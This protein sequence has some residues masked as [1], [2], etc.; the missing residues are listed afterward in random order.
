VFAGT[1]AATAGVVRGDI[2]TSLDGSPVHSRREFYEISRS[3]TVGDRARVALDRSGKK[4]ALELEAAPF[5]EA[6]ADELAQV[7]LGLDLAERTPALAKQYKLASDRGLVVQRVVPHSAA[8]ERGLRAGDLVL[9]LGQ[10]R[11]DDRVSL[12]KAIPKILGQD[13]V[14]VVVQRG[15]GIGSVML[16]LW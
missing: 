3:I 5:P 10:D 16:E 12:R 13:G 6:R 14:V 11:V 8:E 7:L 1:P 4:L 2:L 9:K 15:R